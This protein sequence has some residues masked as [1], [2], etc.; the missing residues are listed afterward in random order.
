M[1]RLKALFRARAIRTTG[2]G[3]YQPK[4]RAAWVA[5]LPEHGARLRAETLYAQLDVLRTQRKKT[6]APTTS[7]LMG[8]LVVVVALHSR[9][10]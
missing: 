2:G 6:K 9:E 5:Q 3:V 10:G 7:C 8:A 4:G 1:L